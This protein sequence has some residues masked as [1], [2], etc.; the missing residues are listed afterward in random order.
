[1]PLLTFVLKK[2][3]ENKGYILTSS[4]D[5]KLKVYK[6]EYSLKLNL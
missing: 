1:M 6:Y 4:V 3:S 2:N 5:K